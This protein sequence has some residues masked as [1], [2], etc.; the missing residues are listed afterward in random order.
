MF[1]IRVMEPGD[2][3]L[4]KFDQLFFWKRQRRD[5]LVKNSRMLPVELIDDNGIRLKE[6]VQKLAALWNLEE[7]FVKWLEEACVFASTAQIRRQYKRRM[8]AV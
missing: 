2:N 5:Y 1:D 4:R 8:R 7:G 3:R 6:C